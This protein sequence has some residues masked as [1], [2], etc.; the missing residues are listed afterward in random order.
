MIDGGGGVDTLTISSGRFLLNPGTLSTF[1]SI[2]TFNLSSNDAAHDITL[3]DDYY[4]TNNGVES[5][6]VTVN[7]SGNS[8]G[9]RV[10]GA[11]LAGTH[12]ISVQGSDGSD[13]VIGGAGNDSLTYATRNTGVV[14]D[15]T[16]AN[17]DEIE[18]II[19]GEG[20][21]TISG[22]LGNQ[23]LQGGD[24]ADFLYGDVNV[25]SFDVA[26][27]NSG[28][29]LWLDAADAS[30]ITDA[31]GGA[32]SEWRDKSGKG[33]DATPFSTG[34]NNNMDSINGLTTLRFNDSGLSTSNSFSFD[35]WSIL[36]VFEDV[37]D[38]TQFERLLDHNYID[39][40]WLGRN[41]TTGDSFGGGV[42]ESVSPYGRFLSVNDGEVHLL[43]SE[44]S[45]TSHSLWQGGD[46]DNAT[47][48]SV[49]NAITSTNTIGIGAWHN[50]ASAH[51][52]AENTNI[53]EIIIFDSALSTSVRQQIE[54]YLAEKWGISYAGAVADDDSLSGGVGD[55]V[56][57]GGI[58]NDVLN[59]GAD[60]D[61]LEGG[62]GNDQLYGDSGM[63]VFIFK[64]S[65]GQDAISSFENPGAAVGDLI[66]IL[67]NV[68]GS[69]ITNWASL[70]P[71]ISQVA[72]DTVID[73]DPGNPGT[74][75]VTLTNLTAADLTSADFV[76]I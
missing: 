69:G 18:T 61:T 52:Q 23:T 68:N 43:G 71:N 76:F 57:S 4:D 41:N 65:S 14:I 66:H 67:S 64:N 46:F 1:N 54:T 72:A 7:L 15:Q 27:F 53:S 56:L 40:F 44:R 22:G 70:Q 55:D 11:T 38:T 25:E 21:D 34:P 33:N 3:T 39:G 10:D 12:A 17:F 19:G 20:S 30:T 47:I 45:G 13:T 74:H 32:V 29:Q 60:N 28:N 35:D 63:D 50:N 59:G 24:G 26:A 6:L 2:E 42:K 62:L 36:T 49:S 9:A 58:G 73:L 51:Q 16:S 37:S 8:T 48:G 31:G 75:T 5:D